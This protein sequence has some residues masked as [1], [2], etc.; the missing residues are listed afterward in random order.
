MA[1]SDQ[2]AVLVPEIQENNLV[3]PEKTDNLNLSHYVPVLLEYRDIN[4]TIIFDYRDKKGNAAARSHVAKL[5]KVKAPISE[6]HKRLKAEYLAITQKMD[7]DKRE[8]LEVVEEMIEHHDKELR[9]VAA[10]EAAEAERK[11]IE[12]EVAASWD[13]AHEMNSMHDQQ[14]ELARQAAEQAKV[15]E[16]QAEAQREIER[17]QREKNIAEEAAESARLQAEAKGERD[18]REAEERER[19]AAEDAERAIKEAEA[20]ADREIAAA[21]ERVRAEEERK[22][23]VEAQAAADLEN[24]KRVH[25]AIIPAVVALGITE[26]KAKEL[27]LAIRNGEVPAL[28]IDY[29]WQ[30]VQK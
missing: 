29:Q 30:P 18:K 9:V 23:K 6:I 28:S 7:A 16:Q 5:R 11:R 12:A 24:I 4:K 27:I 26:D 15:A 20:K 19:K 2:L 14:V 13:L 22:R 8:A 10:E 3:L 21:E 17:Q 1:S 25:W